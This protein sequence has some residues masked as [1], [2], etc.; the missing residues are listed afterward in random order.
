MLLMF[1]FFLVAFRIL[2][3]EFFCSN[4]LLSADQLNTNWLNDDKLNAR[5]LSN[6]TPMI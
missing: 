2:F 1:C 6:Q 4:S 3:L 5:Y